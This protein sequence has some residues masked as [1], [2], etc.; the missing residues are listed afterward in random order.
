MKN[1]TQ[2]FGHV[3]LR[4][5]IVAFTVAGSV[6][7]S[8]L[9][10]PSAAHARAPHGAAVRVAGPHDAASASTS[11]PTP[12]PSGPVRFKSRAR[13][14]YLYEDAAAQIVRHGARD[15]TDPS[16]QWVLEPLNGKSRIR[17]VATGDYMNMQ[18][19][20]AGTTTSQTLQCTPVQ[21]AWGSPIFYIA[22]STDDPSSI[23][24]HQQ[25]WPVVDVSD[26]STARFDDP[27]ALT[28][29]GQLDS[30][31]FTIEQDTAGTATATAT[32]TAATATA[33][34]TASSAATSTSLPT[35]TPLPTTVTYEAEDAFVMGGAGVSAANG[36]YSGSGYTTGYT[37]AGAGA[38]FAVNVPAD[39]AYDVAL[40]YANGSS[41][42]NTLSIW[43]NG[44]VLTRTALP[45]TGG[46]SSWAGKTERLSLRAG[47]NTLAY[48][49]SDGDSGNVNLDNIRVADSQPLAAR[50]ATLPYIEQ[51]AENAAT[52]G[53]VIGPDR[54]FTHLA[55]E[56]SGRKAVTLSAQGQY[57]EFTLTQ[58]ANGMD[59][60]YS[61]PD[62]PDGSGLTAPL[63]LYVDGVKKRDLTLTS[64]YGWFYGSYPFTN[65]PADGAPHHFFDETR[66]LFGALLPAGTKVRVQ[67]D[68]NDTA[69]S[70]TIDLAD[71]E[72][73]PAPYSAPT[74]YLSVTDYEADPTGAT[75][76]TTAIQNAVNAAE[77]QGAGVWIPAGTYAVTA[78][79]ILNHVTVR[80]A[81]PWYTTLR[82]LGVGLYGD[83]AAG[84]GYPANADGNPGASAGVGIYDLSIQGETTNRDD[85]AQV[86]GIGGSL[87]SGSVVQNVWIEHTKVG[88]WLDGPFSGLLVVGS[89]VHD[90]TADGINFHDGIGNA[91]VEETDVRNTGDDGLAMWSERNADDNDL[92]AYNSVRDPILANNFAVYGGHDNTVA[93]NYGADTLTQGGGIHVANRFGAVL[94]SGATTIAGNTLDRTG[95]QDPNWNFGVGAIWFYASDAPMT[96]AIDVADNT[97]NDSTDEA[98]QF[99]SDSDYAI[100]NV[101]VNGGA[102]NKAGTFAV[103]VQTSGSATFN[104]VVA[105]N[106]GVAG[107]DNC[108]NSSG[109]DTFA[110]TATTGD[111]T[112]ATSKGCYTLGGLGT[113]VGTA[114]PVA[115]P[116]YTP[117]A[118]TPAPRTVWLENRA[119][120]QYLTYDAAN[121]RAAFSATLDPGDT[122]QQWVL[123]SFGGAEH[124]CSAAATGTAGCMANQDPNGNQVAYVH[125]GLIYNVW[126]SARW[127]I[128]PGA[129]AGYSYIQNVWQPTLYAGSTQNLGYA[130]METLSSPATAEWAILPISDGVPT[131]TATATPAGGAATATATPAGG[132]STSTPVTTPSPTA[133]PATG[134]PVWLRN[135]GNGQYVTYDPTTNVA[136]FT[137]AP[138]PGDQKAQWR[139]TPFNG[140]LHICSVTNTEPY[141]PGQDTAC[142]S[143]QAWTDTA[144]P[145]PPAAPTPG[146]DGHLPY[147]RVGS[148]YDS[149]GSNQFSLIDQG[150]GYVQIKVT[151]WYNDLVDSSASYGYAD[152]TYTPSS[153]ANAEWQIVPISTTTAVPSVT[154]TTTAV[155]SAT[156]TGTTAPSATSTS[157]SASAS[158]PAPSATGTTAPTMTNTAVPSTATS[159]VVPSTA[160]GISTAVPATATSAAVPPT[161]TSAPTVPPVCQLFALPA[162]DTVPRGGHQAVLVDAAPGSAITLTVRAGYPAQAT[163]YTDS[164]L[165]SS[166]G[167][168]ATLTG[169]RISGG[170]RYAFH[171][172]TSGLALLT[173][174]IPRAARTG[175]VMTQV[176]AQEPCGLFKTIMTFQVRGQAHGQARGA[177]RS[178]A[179]AGPVTLAITLPRGD[180]PPANTGALTRHG[181]LRVTTQGQG[182]TARRV[183]RITYHTHTRPAGAAT[184]GATTAGA[185]HTRPHTL[186]GVAVGTEG[187]ASRGGSAEDWRRPAGGLGRAR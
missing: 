144:Q 40:R 8:P 111:E 16:A 165:G 62:A 68:A 3:M 88:M 114:T 177:R 72:R 167:F 10:T 83:Y 41:A 91:T 66:A 117:A 97:L 162:F 103:Q 69:P 102:I 36:G 145:T 25:W 150:D 100:T 140:K 96:G 163:L 106:L 166:D 143:E 7:A 113:G 82:G 155:P 85:P 159:T 116:T 99:T 173:F 168:G 153:P 53:A 42:T 64:K 2:Q 109:V 123:S 46:W 28:S 23:I 15:A 147:I 94:L 95:Q 105:N 44:L 29:A 67:V 160:T 75:D 141:G 170:Y 136:R 12:L 52:N 63:S 142:W 112:W 81:G 20:A 134:T 32:P 130:D 156:S 26:P 127:T 18:A 13:G 118:A 126:S 4:I 146:P 38:I 89:R 107:V 176:T 115:Q 158:T 71:F 86:N 104:N 47:L 129:D 54:T 148:A 27:A 11:T 55:S 152:V 132:T 35:T 37:K 80:G 74:G 21:D 187:R 19:F 17:N 98:Y 137:A 22:P 131:A 185:A 31:D 79:I 182:T 30:A 174:A 6:L 172:E 161:A 128:L 84:Q 180:A 60:R 70:Y 5:A 59:L 110:L 119:N 73:A 92:F 157:T 57:V 14:D 122:K 120:G 1:L 34:A 121:S 93:H 49:Y 56:A 181:L 151:G 58:P 61:I 9:V 183:L 76:A 186:F 48:T 101:T 39:G 77:Q 51:E 164:S 125:V 45:P 108:Y 184:A 90:V 149:W 175:T 87:G 65:N 50:G 43:A 33:T 171:V 78:H 133:P 178:R 24:I 179:A 154:G 135:R 169:T 124:I 138:D 139:L